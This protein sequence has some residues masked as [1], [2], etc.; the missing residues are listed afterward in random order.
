[1]IRF[2][3][4]KEELEILERDWKSQKSEF[5][6]VFGRRRIGKTTLLN[7]FV[8]DKEGIKYTA[9]DVNK[10]VQA[11]QFK[12]IAANYLKDDFL[13]KQE[14]FEWASLLE[15]L[16]KVLDKK[17][18][19]YIWI[20]E[21][22]YVIKNDPPVASVL[23]K[24]CDNFLRNSNIFFMASGSIFGLMSEKILSNSSPL[25]GR[26]T[27]DILLK[28]IPLIFINEFLNFDFEDLLK[29]ALTI[30]G[31]PEYLNIASKHRNFLEF[32]SNEFLKPEGYFFR[33][34]VYLLS[35]EFKE[36]RT[37]FSILNAIAYGNSRPTEIANFIGLNSR[38]I[39]P[40]LELLISYGFVSRQASILGDRKR[41]VYCINDNFFDFWFNFVHKNRES[42]EKREC[43]INKGELNAYFGK[44][45][46]IFIRD[47][48]S[49][50]F[51]SFEY[52]GR[53]W[54]KDMEIDVVAFNE[55]K[56]E[57]LFGECKWQEKLN[58]LDVLHK[59]AEKA[60]YVEW[61]NG[62]RKETLAI[63][64]KSFSKKARSFEGKKVYCFDL[65]D[66]E[67]LL[68]RH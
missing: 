5:V 34:P 25:Y 42:I 19:M 45:F 56:M 36:I 2:I 47:N 23:Q 51:K 4:R 41:G 60:E 48:L 59:L 49:A 37:Y 11:G 63:F 58:A 9:E 27:R 39:Y 40:Y 68:K 14:I 61:N 29:T 66:M 21:F 18:R 50:F 26:R 55:K 17:K 67:K 13:L 52:S 62:K 57:I 54:H 12:N 6:V 32:I 31:V 1:M 65:R 22:S 30:N 33:E 28:P 38:E 3:D 8:K 46:E 44:R 53:W 15:Y 10:A 16:P 35:Q 24:F 43:Q 7:E 64:A 20:D